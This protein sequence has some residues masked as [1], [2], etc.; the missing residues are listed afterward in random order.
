MSLSHYVAELSHRS[1]LVSDIEES[2]EKMAKAL[3]VQWNIWTIVPEHCF[4]NGRA[5][6]FTFRVAFAKIAGARI[7]L[8]SP[9]QCKKLYQAYFD[10]DGE[11]LPHPCYS[12]P[13]LAGL[14]KAI[15]D[16]IQQGHQIIQQAYTTGVFE[17]CILETPNQDGI[18][19]LFYINGLSAPD[20]IIGN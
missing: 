3:N 17:F 6:E 20:K 7:E 18:V 13:S 2:A 12:Y 15:S 1:Q 10:V 8:I 4:V 14:K 11:G 16:L 5:S 19:E 9:F